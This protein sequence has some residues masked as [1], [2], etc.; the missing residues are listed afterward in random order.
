VEQW[1]GGSGAVPH[2]EEVGEGPGPGGGR[3]GVGGWRGGSVPMKQG[4]AHA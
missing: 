1:V 4:R 3:C 2:G